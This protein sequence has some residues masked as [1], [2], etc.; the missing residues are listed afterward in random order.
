MQLSAAC[1]VAEWVSQKRRT[2]SGEDCSCQG[3]NLTSGNLSPRM[4]LS[5]GNKIFTLDLDQPKTL[6]PTVAG[7]S[8]YVFLRLSEWSE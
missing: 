6:K 5:W 1:E 7:K 2:G 3:S 8:E 4:P